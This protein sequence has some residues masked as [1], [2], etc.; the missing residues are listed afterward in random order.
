[1]ISPKAARV[2]LCDD[3]PGIDTYIARGI[4]ISERASDKEAFRVEALPDH[5]SLAWHIDSLA[6]HLIGILPNSFFERARGQQHSTSANPTSFP[7]R[8]S[9]HRRFTA[10][11]RADILSSRATHAA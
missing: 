3:S 1:M 4:Q 9:Q 2:R 7:A 11:C 5:D 10:T 6:C 8:K